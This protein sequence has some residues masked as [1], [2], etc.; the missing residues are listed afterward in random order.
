MTRFQTPS[1]EFVEISVETLRETDRAYLVSD[2][3]EE[4]VWVPKSQITVIV[5]REGR[6]TLIKLPEWLARDKGLI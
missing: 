1:G 2:G 5:Q 3:S 6:P 4:A